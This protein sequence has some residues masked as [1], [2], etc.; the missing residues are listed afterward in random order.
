MISCCI[1]STSPLNPCVR[2]SG[3]FDYIWVN[4]T[5]L[6]QLLKAEDLLSPFAPLSLKQ[7]GEFNIGNMSVDGSASLAMHCPETCYR[8]VTIVTHSSLNCIPWSQQILQRVLLGLVALDGKLGLIV[9][10]LS[11]SDI[12]FSQRIDSTSIEHNSNIIP[13]MKHDS[14]PLY[15][16]NIRNQQQND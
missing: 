2:T 12:G 6:V 1:F 5:F 8:L 7:C 15:Q 3:Q 16:I 10:S 13:D 9:N 11:S 4:F 14:N